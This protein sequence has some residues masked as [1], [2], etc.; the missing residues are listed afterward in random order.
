LQIRKSLLYLYQL[1]I[2]TIE[3]MDNVWI[4]K[5]GMTRTEVEIFYIESINDLIKLGAPEEMAR[6]IVKETLKKTL[7][8]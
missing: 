5:T 4:A 8:L 7:G 3:I 6:E 1:R 2:K